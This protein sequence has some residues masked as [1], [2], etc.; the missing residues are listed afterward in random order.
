MTVLVVRPEGKCEQ[1]CNYFTE[2]GLDC[3]GLPLM[4]RVAHQ[5]NLAALPAMLISLETGDWV[6]STSTFASELA[7]NTL[8]NIANPD[9][10]S[11]L[12]NEVKWFAIGEKSAHI[13]MSGSHHSPTHVSIPEQETSEGLLTYLENYL[14]CDNTVEVFP[15]KKRKIII[16]KGV[17]GRALL[18]NSLQK[19][20][21]QVTEAN[22]YQ[23]KILE[24]AMLSK[25][26]YQPNISCVVVTSGELLQA[27]F[28]YFENNN[29]WLT[30]LPWVVVSERMA[31]IAK[32]YG[33]KTTFVSGGANNTALFSTV[34][35]VNASRQ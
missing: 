18:K 27:T 7:V 21:H 8:A 5:E 26:W 2:Q 24:P 28:Q 9:R 14:A 13:L 23:R 16:L 25:S 34:S 31:N 20:G 11:F 30:S 19:S 15:E 3:V 29:Q 17:G 35:V 12:I 6:I 4:A 33:I 32:D 10:A 22:V 1:T